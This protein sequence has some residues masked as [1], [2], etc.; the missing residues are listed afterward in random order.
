MAPEAGV[1]EEQAR[2][3]GRGRRVEPDPASRVSEEWKWQGCGQWSRG[4][5]GE[6]G[7]QE[8]ESNVR[9]GFVVSRG[10]ETSMER[11]IGAWEQSCAGLL[12][13]ADATSEACQFATQNDISNIAICTDS[14][15]AIAAI[16]SPGTL[17]TCGSIGIENRLNQI[18]KLTKYQC[19]I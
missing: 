7:E 2:E 13:L 8:A 15:A 1:A 19:H 4:W 3:V 18:Y 6:A 5:K 11:S 14:A 10:D 17:V 16:L 9:A 12:A